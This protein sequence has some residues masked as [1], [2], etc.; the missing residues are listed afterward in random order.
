MNR[1]QR[2]KSALWRAVGTKMAVG[3]CL[4]AFLGTSIGCEDEKF[5]EAERKEVRKVLQT[6][7]DMD[8]DP[9]VQAETL[10]VLEMIDKPSLNHFAKELVGVEGSPMVRV[11]AL[12]VLLA[13]GFEDSRRVTLAEFNNASIAEQKAILDAVYEYGSPPLRRVLTSRAL[14]SHD[15]GLRRKAFE[16]GPLTRLREAYKQ[17][18]TTYLKN[19]L[20]PEIGQFVSDDDDRVASAALGA[21]VETGQQERAQPLLDK[22]QDDDADRDERLRA[23]RILGQAHVEAAVPYFEEVLDS[24]HVSKEGEFVLPKRIDKEM[25]RA[26]TL[27]MVA[28]GDEKYVEQAQHYLTNASGDES[29]E[30]LT[31]MGSNPSQDAAISLKIAMQDARK[32]VRYRAIELYSAHPKANAAAFIAALRGTDF[33]TKKRIA[34]VLAKNYPE[35][36]AKHLGER[37]ADKKNRLDTLELLRDVILTDEQVAVLEPLA[38]QLF[39][40][41]SS[42]DEKVAPLAALL[43]VKVADDAKTR[44]L[45]ANVDDPHTRYAYLEYLVRTNPKENVEFFRKNFYSDLYA[46]RLMSAAGMMLAYDAGVEPGKAAQQANNN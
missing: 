39:E 14:R 6:G 2:T 36:W 26:A 7:V 28:S 13:N 33:D 12:R 38:D 44:K 32:P 1:A 42:D 35:Q 43:L 11:A 4:A 5:G 41:A 17:K 24:V 9:Y 20:F 18:K 31:A 21:L 16:V 22:L 8:S 30:V 46:I 37:L 25:V 27:G 15:P 34:Q 45:L 10:R 23:A 19:T 40:L 29:I 3:L